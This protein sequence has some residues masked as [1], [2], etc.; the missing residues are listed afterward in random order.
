[1]STAA[2]LLSE[3]DEEFAS[4]RKMLERVPENK[5]AWKPHEKS[6]PLGKLASHVAA[7]PAYTAVFIQGRGWKPPEAASKAELLELFDKNAAACREALA[8]A[9]EDQLTKE[10]PVLPGLTKPLRTVLQGRI[11]NHLI[12]HRGQ[13]SVYLRLL[14]VAVPGMY[15][16]SADEK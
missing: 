10:I 5:L 11:M 14:D 8:G 3:F 2:A 13:L 9:S 7:L 4:T 16:P 15:G 12:H 6:S 1:M